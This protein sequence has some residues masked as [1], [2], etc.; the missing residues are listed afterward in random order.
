M[1]QLYSLFIAYTDTVRRSHIRNRNRVLAEN[2]QD[3]DHTKPA[4]KEEIEALKKRCVV[5]QSTRGR[6]CLIGQVRG[7]Q[8]CRTVLESVCRVARARRMG[9]SRLRA[10]TSLFTDSPDRNGHSGKM[11]V[12]T[13]TLKLFYNG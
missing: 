6:G 13:F 7:S 8:V 12:S 10:V 11:V 2:V 4:T 9:E 3:I 5:E 1:H